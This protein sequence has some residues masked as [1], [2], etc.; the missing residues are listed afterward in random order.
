M[1]RRRY[2]LIQ[3][4]VRNDMKNFEEA[5]NSKMTICSARSVH[6]QFG[7]IYG[8]SFWHGGA[9]RAA[10]AIMARDGN[11]ISI[12][13]IRY[14]DISVYINIFLPDHIVE[15]WWCVWSWC[16]FVHSFLPSYNCGYLTYFDQT[17]N[18]KRRKYR[19]GSRLYYIE[20]GPAQICN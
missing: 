12:Y 3:R 2:P 18:I 10:Q 5:R 6:R 9:P 15:E 4:M 16:S 8:L 7:R 14:I 11:D 1:H 19:E 17:W 20:Y 13:C